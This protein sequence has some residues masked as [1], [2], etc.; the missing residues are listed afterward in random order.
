MPI[1]T[2]VINIRSGTNSV[3]NSSSKHSSVDLGWEQIEF[4]AEDD[5]HPN[6]NKEL[7]FWRSV[8]HQFQSNTSSQSSDVNKENR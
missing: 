1:G 7:E 5:V 4:P 8:S 6:G 2:P 3:S